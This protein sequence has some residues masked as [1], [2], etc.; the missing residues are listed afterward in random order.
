MNETKNST[1]REQISESYSDRISVSRDSVRVSGPR[2][3]CPRSG[4]GESVW[5]PRASHVARA[6]WEAWTAC[7]ACAQRSPCGRLA[8]VRAT[9]VCSAPPARSSLS[10][11]GRLP[12]ARSVWRPLARDCKP[13]QREV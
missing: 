2:R 1:R 7:V 9:L 8:G 13:I 3:V 4:E 5:A 11:R 12:S 10:H 6:G